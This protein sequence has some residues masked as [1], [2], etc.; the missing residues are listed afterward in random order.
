MAVIITILVL[1]LKAP[2][3]AEPAALVKLWP[4]FSIYLVSFFLTTIFW[5]NHHGLI[6]QARRVTPQLL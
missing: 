3:S 5:V 1:D 2:H 6:A 4:S